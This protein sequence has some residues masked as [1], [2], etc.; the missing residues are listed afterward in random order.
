M[1]SLAIYLSGLAKQGDFTMLER[2]QS[3]SRFLTSIFWSCSLFSA[4]T[5][6]AFAASAAF[7][8]Q[9]ALAGCW[10]LKNGSNDTI[11]GSATTAT[12]TFSHA[13]TN[14]SIIIVV[15]TNIG[16]LAINT[17][18]DTA[19]NTYLDSGAGEIDLDGTAWSIRLYY[20]LNTSTTASNTITEHDASSGGNMSIIAEE[21]T[22]GATSSP[23]DQHTSAQ[24]VSIGGA[25]GQNISM[26]FTTSQGGELIVAMPTPENDQPVQGSMWS[27]TQYC[28]YPSGNSCANDSYAYL[29]TTV[30]TAKGLFTG[31]WSDADTSD[32]W[33]GIMMS[34]KGTVC[35]PPH[36]GIM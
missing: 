25:T 29:S 27:G 8:P 6:A 32:V 17:P 9:T 18:T 11:L 15:V 22:G 7:L 2:F 28:A 33:S 35:N 1:R 30:Q 26:S 10:A 23:V 14:P 3:R 34:L 20:A 19:G 31:T 13:L 21:W 5:G 16:S 24:N 4:V 12:E 36:A